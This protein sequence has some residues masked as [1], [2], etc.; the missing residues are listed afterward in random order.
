MAYIG[1]R[2]DPPSRLTY[3][4][5]AP[6]GYG[7]HKSEERSTEQGRGEAQPAAAQPS[8]VVGME[9]SVEERSEA[10]TTRPMSVTTRP[11]SAL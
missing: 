7:P 8:Y 11:T 10:A 5:M 3:I 1:P 6:Y 9:R 4:V 2:G